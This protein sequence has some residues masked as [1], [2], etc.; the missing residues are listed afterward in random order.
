MGAFF[1]VANEEFEGSF[2]PGGVALGIIDE[3]KDGEVEECGLGGA[4]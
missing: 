3:A 2:V 1:A 4:S